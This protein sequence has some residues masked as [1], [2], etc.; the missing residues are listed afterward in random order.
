M[1]TCSR[2]FAA[3]K[4]RRLHLIQAHGYPKEYFFAV[5]NKGV[6]GLLKKWGEGASLLRKPWKPRENEA[7]DGAEEAEDASA[8]DATSTDAQ[9]D[10]Q[11]T[12]APDEDDDEE[13]QVLLGKIQIDRTSM[14]AAAPRTD[15]ST[16]PAKP[17]I[18]PESERNGK[19]KMRRSKRNPKATKDIDHLAEELDSLSLVPPSIQFG[20]GAKRGA[21]GHARAP[22]GSAGRGERAGD[23]DT[24]DVDHRSGGPPLPPRGGALRGVM[25]ARGRGPRG[26]LGALG[27]GIGRGT[28]PGRGVSKESF[29]RT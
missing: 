12:D 16:A 26:S 15:G 18:A 27:S 24:M 5:T 10:Q 9:T 13:D 4:A 3:P 11:Y 17:S 14:Q 2:H 1:E 29:K 6:G 20:R 22:R 23:L 7:H 25:R 21:R 28:G 8:D 19:G